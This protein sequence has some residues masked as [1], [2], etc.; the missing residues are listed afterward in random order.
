MVLSLMA[1]NAKTTAEK[2]EPTTPGKKFRSPPYPTFGLSECLKFAEKLWE[3]ERF[4]SALVSTAASHW[5]Y[6][7]KSS[8]GLLAVASMKQFGLLVEEGSNEKRTVKLSGPALSLL[9]PATAK[10]EK[11]EIIKEAA[12]APRI[13]GELWSRYKVPL[14]SDD[15]IRGYLTFDRKYAESAANMLIKEYKDTIRFANLTEND[16]VPEM[17]SAENPTEGTKR[18]DGVDAAIRH[19]MNPQPTTKEFPIPLP[20]GNVASIKVPFPMSEDDFQM[21]TSLIEAFK[22][23]LV[24][25]SESK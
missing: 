5:G 23:G 7:P 8:G 10:E 22:K 18:E 2:P 19:F 15:T 12:L 24:R 6:K 11:D 25:T 21:F 14:P 17:K 20:S 16:S 4:H 13:H 3:K 1:E 9:N